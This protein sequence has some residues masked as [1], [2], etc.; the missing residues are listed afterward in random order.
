MNKK[1]ILFIGPFPPPFGGIANHTKLLF[2]SNLNNYF[3]L[4][5]INLNKN[6]GL[7]EVVSEKSK[8][9][10]KKFLYGLVRIL[11]TITLEKPDI[12]Y[13]KTSS[14]YGIFRET[15]YMII[16]RLFSRGKIV[17]HFH[18]TFKPYKKKFPFNEQKK[19]S[20]IN[21]LL[22]NFCFGKAHKIIFLSA[23]F[24]DEFIP[25]LWEKNRKKSTYID[26]F[27]KSNDFSYK[28][29]E[30]LS[31]KKINILFISRLSKDKG[32]FDIINIVNDVINNNSN[33]CF[34]FCGASE[35]W[36]SLKNIENSICDLEKNGYIKFHGLVSGEKKKEIFSLSDIMLFPT[37]DDVFPNVV[38]E[39]LIQGLPIITTKIGVI[40][41]IIEEN[42]NGFFISPGDINALKEKIIYLVN[43]PK[44]INEMSKKNHLKAIQKY[45]IS[46]AVERFKN[47]F[48]EI[49]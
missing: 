26:H 34:H 33:V 23:C 11:K 4:I 43:N 44:K 16:I 38:L 46:I 8:I 10:Y 7:T 19:D 49:I 6:Y 17:L 1:K 20:I 25:I 12:V 45:D 29:K 2:E 48:F 32:F 42:I 28:E 40:P 14:S 35:K 18:G 30:D 13:L 39:G 5:K 27:V 21:K 36:D 15:L 9:K 47:L 37:Y 3:D 31:Y 22:I 41:Y 24:L